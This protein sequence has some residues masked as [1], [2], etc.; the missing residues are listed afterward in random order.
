MKSANTAPKTGM[1]ARQMLLGV[2]VLVSSVSC[3]S[4]SAILQREGVYSAEASLGENSLPAR[5]ELQRWQDG[6][7]G[8][9]TITL[10]MPF[11][12]ALRSTDFAADTMKFA[13]SA[14]VTGMTIHF[15]GDSVQG[16]IWLSGD[17]E[18]GLVGALLGDE[19]VSDSLF[20]QFDLQRWEG[21]TISQHGRGEA[22]P[23]FSPDGEIVYFSTYENDFSSLTI[24]RSEYRNGSWT[25]AEVAPFSGTYSDRAPMISPD[26]TR[27]IF[28]STRPVGTDTAASTSYDLW[29]IDLADPG[30]GSEP[31]LLSINSP[32]SDYQP[33]L[34][35]NG[36]LYFSSERPG[37]YGGQDLYRWDGSSTVENLG[38][39]INSD[40]DEMSV[41]VAPDGDY[42]IFSTSKTYAGHIGNDDLYL[43]FRQG[44]EWTDPVNLGVPIN[45][46][47][48]EYGATVSTDGRHLYFTSDRHPPANIYRVELV[49]I[50]S[51][52]RGS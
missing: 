18:L 25:P 9:L 11:N 6:Y 8:R 38:S 20:T 47:A 52:V 39:V 5:I 51:R 14:P 41:F 42:I 26:G 28:A 23:T 36:E 48:N 46:F 27:L 50:L 4:A 37:G 17:R 31:K 21:E 29:E 33:S 10:G 3:N 16:S 35:R 49:E 7:R 30:S 45:S 12:V 34:T 44:A 40:Q 43:S 32:E 2:W 24:M 22:F 1:V 19:L 13:T 15:R